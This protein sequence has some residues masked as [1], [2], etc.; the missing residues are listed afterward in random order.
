MGNA[1]ATYIWPFRLSTT[2]AL[3]YSGPTYDDAANQIPLGG[4]VLWDFRASFPIGERTEL[5]GRVENVTDRHYE[6]AHQYGTL[7]R[8]AYIGGRITF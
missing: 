3:R 7:G 8:S 5:Y 6:T 4:Y 1:T 2:L